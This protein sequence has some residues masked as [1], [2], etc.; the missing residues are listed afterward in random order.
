MFEEI[1]DGAYCLA[2]IDFASMCCPA[3]RDGE[4]LLD[5]LRDPIRLLL[6]YLRDPANIRRQVRPAGQSSCTPVQDLQG[7]TYLMS[8]PGGK[9]P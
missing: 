8:Q 7:R 5:Y 2:Q 9:L 1:D 6:Q 4:E 3:P